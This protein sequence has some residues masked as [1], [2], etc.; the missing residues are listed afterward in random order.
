[1]KIA[2]EFLPEEQPIVIGVI[3]RQIFHARAPLPLDLGRRP[4]LRCHCADQPQPDLQWNAEVGDGQPAARPL[5]EACVVELAT[6]GKPGRRPAHPANAS[7]PAAGNIIGI[8]DQNRISSP[9]SRSV[10]SH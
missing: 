8:G 2:I 5:D 9:V 1:M 6:A 3:T 10:A 4:S 7:A